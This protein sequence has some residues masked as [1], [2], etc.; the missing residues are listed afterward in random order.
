MSDPQSYAHH[1]RYVPGYHFATFGVV[2]VHLLWQAWKVTTD[3]SVDRLITFLLAV[4]LVGLFFY[5]RIFALTVQNRVIRLEERLRLARLLPAD[6]QP[7]ADRLTTDQLIGLRFASD[8]ELAER[9]REA[10]GENLGRKQIKQRI[11]TWR[12][13]TLRV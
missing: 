1:A 10:V 5:P 13:D 6:L 11:R 2:V 4:A 12:P 8:G 3:F 9:V 7:L